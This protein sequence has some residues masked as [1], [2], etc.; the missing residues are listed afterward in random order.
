MELSLARRLA[1]GT[2]SRSHLELAAYC[3]HRGAQ[4]ALGESWPRVEAHWEGEALEQRLAVGFAH[5][6]V[7]WGKEVC[8]RACVVIAESVCRAHPPQTAEQQALEAAKRW[9]D[10][11]CEVHAQTADAART[12]AWEAGCAISRETMDPVGF[13]PPD[14]LADFVADSRCYYL[15]ATYYAAAC[16]AA[17]PSRPHLDPFQETVVLSFINATLVGIEPVSTVSAA[18]QKWATDE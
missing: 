5:G 11:P 1:L 13:V 15:L 6:L 12:G 10:C 8:V 14:R 16:A 4:L 2:L 7:R 9:L 17:G 3:G 18:L